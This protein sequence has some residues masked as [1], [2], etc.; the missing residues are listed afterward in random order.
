MTWPHY[1]EPRPKPESALHRVPW[2]TLPAPFPP[3]ALEDAKDYARITHDTEDEVARVILR[4][5]VEYAET[6]TRRSI[7]LSL[8]DLVLDHFPTNG[9]VLRRPP[10]VDVVLVQ[11]RDGDGVWST[12]AEEDY[13]VEIDGD[14]ARILPVHGGSWPSDVGG[15]P[16]SV[17]AR[18]RAGY[19]PL[20]EIE[21]VPAAPTIPFNLKA[22]I[23]ELF[24]FRFDT[25]GIGST[26]RLIEVSVPSNVEAALWSERVDL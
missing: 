9:I 2:P 16:R 14:H 13:D 21:D 7:T 8:W 15:A 24:A 12:V 20:W 1:A 19:D 25:R 23:L 17:R 22:T 5:A 18:Y 3:I 4:Q 11:Y 6:A 26:N 10:V